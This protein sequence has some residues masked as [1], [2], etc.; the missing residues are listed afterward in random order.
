MGII[1]LNFIIGMGA[2]CVFFIACLKAYTIG[3]KHGKQIAD[4]VIPEVN[5]NP[6]EPIK[7][8]LR[9]KTEDKQQELLNQGYANIMGYNGDAKE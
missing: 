1:Y 3:L 9:D 4:K 7:E 8:V 2:G 5:I 6:I